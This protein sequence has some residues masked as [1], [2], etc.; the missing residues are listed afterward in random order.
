MHDVCGKIVNSMGITSSTTGGWLSTE[1]THSI[2]AVG[3]Y[4]AKLS[5]VHKLFPLSTQGLS[6][7]ITPH[8][9]LI[10]HYFY[11]VSTAPITRTTKEKFKER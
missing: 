3:T 1:S 2:L 11:P 4:S 7:Q 9:P 8:L 10:E 6:T 5:F